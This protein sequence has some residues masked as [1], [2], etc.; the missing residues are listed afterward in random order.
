M[1]HRELKDVVHKSTDPLRCVL[2]VDS[3]KLLRVLGGRAGHPLAISI[4]FCVRF[5][6]GAW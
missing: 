4:E 5:L 2:P 6:G 3:T 1:T